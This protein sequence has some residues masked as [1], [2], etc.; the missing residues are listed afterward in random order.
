MG[1]VLIRFQRRLLECCT[2]TLLEKAIGDCTDAL[3]EKAIGV[4][5]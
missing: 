1:T 5:Y 4:L 3:S 2:D